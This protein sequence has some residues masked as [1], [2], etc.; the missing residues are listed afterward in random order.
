MLCC[1]SPPVRFFSF[2]LCRTS[3][4]VS[5]YVCVCKEQKLVADVQCAIPTVPYRYGW[6]CNEIRGEIKAYTDTG[7]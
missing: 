7:A 2:F 1:L 3:R 4:F 5:L 6:E